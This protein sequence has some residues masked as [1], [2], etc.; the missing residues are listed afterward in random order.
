MGITD[1]SIGLVWLQCIGY[2]LLRKAAFR[3]T[4]LRK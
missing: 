2:D 3:L 1:R 4:V